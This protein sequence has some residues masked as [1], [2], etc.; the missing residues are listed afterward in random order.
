[1]IVMDET[2]RLLSEE[3]AASTRIAM[4][5]RLAVIGLITLWMASTR[6]AP[7]LYHTLLA[8]AVLAGITFLHLRL[9][10]SYDR[11]RWLPYLFYGLDAVFLVV[12]AGLSTILIFYHVPPSTIYH[13]GYFPFFF[14]VLIGTGLS[15]SPRV[16]LWTGFCIAVGWLGL[17][18]WVDGFSGLDWADMPSDAEGEVFLS[19]LLSP[20]W[21]DKFGRIQEAIIILAGAGLL[22]LIVHR[23][24]SLV[25]RQVAAERNRRAVREAFGQYVPASIADAMIAS[26][27][28]LPPEEREA[29]VLFC[30][31][32]GFTRMTGRLGPERTLKVLNAY[33]DMVAQAVGDQG[34]VITQ[35]Q[36]DAALAVFNAPSD[37]PDH[38][39]SALEAARAIRAACADQ[40]FDGER[41]ACRIGIATGPLVAGSVGGA[42]RRGYTVHGDTV[43][44]AAR[45]EALNKATGTDILLDPRAA[46]AIG[47]A[48]TFRVIEKQRIAGREDPVTVYA[49]P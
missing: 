37:L 16:V 26:G 34:G 35:F 31:L 30:D 13:F 42:G 44:L 3:R 5:G 2:A 20:D 6:Q 40:D 48:T 14:L 1:M 28:T 11:Y 47:D 17:F 4:W 19:Y 12:A 39:K 21:T 46:E 8:C 24:R 41:L 25:A 45:L 49:V 9:A 33:F 15:L 7:Q 23:M 27:G 38:E 32:A 18:A 22:G 29:T 43:N 10:G 36:G